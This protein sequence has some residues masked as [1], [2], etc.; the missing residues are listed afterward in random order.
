[1]MEKRSEWPRVFFHIFSGLAIILLY[2]LTGIGKESALIIFGAVTLFFLLG[3]ILRQLYPGVNRIAKRIFGV[4]MHSKEEKKLG[5]STYYV[6]G[7]W[8]TMLMFNRLITCISILFL[9]CGDTPAKIVGEKWGRRRIGRK[10]LEGSLAN[11][12]ACLLVGLPILKF[13]GQPHALLTSFLGALGATGA[14][15][16]PKVDNLAI[17]LLSGII[18]T[19]LWGASP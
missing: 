6:A 4:L 13:L 10:T 8:L 2:G 19:V 18:L 9:I 7:C 15:M 14:E 16:I 11:L 5:S 12:V 17:P 3:D 1:M